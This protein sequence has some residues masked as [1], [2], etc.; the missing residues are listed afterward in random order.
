[1][2]MLLHRSKERATQIWMHTQGMRL[3]ETDKLYPLQQR[4]RDEADTGKQK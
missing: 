2:H 3:Q 4:T 1:M